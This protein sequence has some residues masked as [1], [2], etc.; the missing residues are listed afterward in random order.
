VRVSKQVRS[1]V[2]WASF[3]RKRFCRSVPRPALEIG[4]YDKPKIIGQGVFYF[5]VLDQDG[6][7]ARAST[8]PYLTPDDCPFVHFVSPTGDLRTIGRKFKSVFSS[9]AIEHQPDLIRHLNDVADILEP[10]GAYYL[11]I[12]DKRFCFDHFRPETTPT[13]VLRAKGRSVP[14]VEKV[15]EHYEERAHNIPLLHWLGLHGRKRAYDVDERV[16]QAKRGEYVDCHV[17]QF[18]PES[19]KRLLLDLYERREIPLAPE[20]VSPTAPGSIEFRAVLRLASGERGGRDR[21]TGIGVIPRRVLG[22]A[23]LVE[24]SA[25]NV[26]GTPR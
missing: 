21:I 22:H 9:H 11:I 20:S 23:D 14:T 16:E 15:R 13:E 3:R 6:L 10:G 12:P 26:L 2:R 18:T 5:D 25:D 7:K 24:I 19:F 8:V 17:W 1:A 4:P